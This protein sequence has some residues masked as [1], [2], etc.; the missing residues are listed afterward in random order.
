MEAVYSFSG[1]LFQTEVEAA[2]VFIL[3]PTE[4]ADEIAATIPRRSG[5]GSV[6]VACHIGSTEWKTSIF[7]SKEFGSYVLP[8]KR[9]VREREKIA[10]GDTAEVSIRIVEG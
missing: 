7:P 3:L 2:W 9:S 5:F 10:T 4:A 1:E 6:R 8:V